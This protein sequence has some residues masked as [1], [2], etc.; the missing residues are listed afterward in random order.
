VRWKNAVNARL[1]LTPV[2]ADE[3]LVKFEEL[4]RNREKTVALTG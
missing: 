4:E 1:T 3:L 2:Q